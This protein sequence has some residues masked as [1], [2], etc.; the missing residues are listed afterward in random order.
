M[1]GLALVLRDAVHEH[2]GWRFSIMAILAGAALSL[3]VSP[4]ALA[5]ASAVAF[6]L[7]EFADLAVYAPLRR[8]GLAL[9]VLVSGVAGAFIDS[10][11]FVWLAFGTLNLAVGTTLAKLYASALAAFILSARAERASVPVK[12]IR[13]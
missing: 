8:R 12:R 1:I 9:A 11:L 10:M 6:A 5:L 13:T 2:F 7:A 3:A 4:P